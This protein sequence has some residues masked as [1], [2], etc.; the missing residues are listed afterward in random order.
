[1]KLSFELQGVDKVI[2]VLNP[3]VYK[4]ALSATLNETGNSVKTESAREIQKTYKMQ[5]KPL[6]DA[7]KIDKS[8]VNDLQWSL[9]TSKKRRNV[10]N[11]GARRVKL[12]V[13]VDIKSGRKLIKGAFIPK[14]QKTVFKRVGKARLPIKPITT[15]SVSQM[16]TSSVQKKAKEVAREKSKERFQHNFDHFVGK[17]K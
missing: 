14:N 2:A 4:K 3:T 9:S 8:S 6:K 15:L 17:I 5:S 16:F 1:M 7:M 13:T 11:F 10:I 12:G